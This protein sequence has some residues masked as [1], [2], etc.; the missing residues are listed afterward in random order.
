MALVFPGTLALRHPAPANG[1]RAF[2]IT[3][4]IATGEP[5]VCFFIKPGRIDRSEDIV[6][7]YNAFNASSSYVIRQDGSLEPDVVRCSHPG[8]SFAARLV[9]AGWR[10][11][12]SA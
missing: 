11:V 2:R 10:G 7:P 8:C 12:A 3:T 5:T 4:G 9:L 1:Y 6:R